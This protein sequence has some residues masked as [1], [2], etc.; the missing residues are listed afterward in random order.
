[1]QIVR[2]SYAL[3]KPTI[4]VNN[5]DKYVGEEQK[6]KEAMC[7]KLQNKEKPK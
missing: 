6:I 2:G 1:M 3:Q 4:S 7:L 5:T